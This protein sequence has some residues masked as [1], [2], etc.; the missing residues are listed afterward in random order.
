MYNVNLNKDTNFI[1]AQDLL[2]EVKNELKIYHERSI[3]DDSYFYPVIRN[4][5]GKMGAKVYPVG[6]I[7]LRVDDYKA[8]LPKDFHRLIMAVGCFSYTVTNTPNIDNPQLYQVSEKQ[9]NDYLISKPSETCLD[10]C[11]ENFYVIQRF[12]SFD[13]TFTD[14]CPLSI[15]NSSMPYCAN[16]CFNKGVLSQHQIDL[17]KDTLIAG[18]RTGYVYMDYLQN[19]EKHDTDG[20]DLLIP[21][22]AQIR[23]WV[24]MAC[25]KKGL[26]IVYWN[27]DDDVERRLNYV[28]QELTILEAQAR[29]FIKAIDMKE[30]YDMRKLFFGRYKKF[31]EQVYGPGRSYLVT[32]NSYYRR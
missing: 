24:K 9:I 28:K 25:I 22:Y 26:E 21:D 17:S 20:V 30:M 32:E 12:E 29:T 7:V 19:L 2:A 5:L 3:L 31:N 6:K 18:F 16:D 13:V 15:S 27:K 4:C 1:T 23:E 8:A 14:Y 11:G 10:E